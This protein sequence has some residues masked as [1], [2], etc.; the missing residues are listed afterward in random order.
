[1]L[2]WLYHGLLSDPGFILR[3]SM[4]F[5]SQGLME[6]KI[7]FLRRNYI[8]EHES[9]LLLFS[10]KIAPEVK[11]EAAASPKTKSKAKAL[12][13]KKIVLK[14]IHSHTHKRGLH[15]THLLVEN[16]PNILRR[17]PPGETTW[18]TF[19]LSSSPD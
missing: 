7:I 1:M 18:T 11:K 5:H 10:L 6:M 8:S 4:S 3:K 16:S 9:N 17:S 15:I 2:S 14:G 13:T 19:P 12:K